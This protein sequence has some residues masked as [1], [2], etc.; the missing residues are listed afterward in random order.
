MKLSEV[1]ESV[2]EL[3][4]GDNSKASELLEKRVYLNMAIRDVC[5]RCE[6]S[7]LIDIWDE[8]KSDVFRRL[9]SIENDALEYTHFYIMVPNVTT[10]GDDDHIPMDEQ[11]A[12]AVIYF[13]CSYLSNKKSIDYAKLADH[14]INLYKT[15]SVDITQYE[16]DE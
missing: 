4:R 12:M 10:L 5:S 8:T 7:A 9:H 6:P 16:I 2:A 15:N 14:V 3:L 1:N 13:M 11:L